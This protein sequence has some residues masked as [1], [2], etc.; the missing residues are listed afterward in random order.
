MLI[1][2]IC[3][4]STN[5]LTLANPVQTGHKVIIADYCQTQ[6]GVNSHEQVQKQ[7]AVFPGLRAHQRRWELLD[8]RWRT[9][10]SSRAKRR[11]WIFVVNRCRTHCCCCCYW[12]CFCRWLL[13]CRFCL[14]FSNL[15]FFFLLISE[16]HGYFFIIIESSFDHQENSLNCRSTF[17]LIYIKKGMC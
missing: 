12:R 3:P 9:I 5:L 2:I 11:P 7:P 15:T 10:W 16:A 6:E 14:R 17:D 4:G 1:I 13:L 8:R